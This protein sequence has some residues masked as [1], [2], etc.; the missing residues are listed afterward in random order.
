M[1]KMVNPAELKFRETMQDKVSE[2]INL[3]QEYEGVYTAIIITSDKEIVDG[4]NRTKAALALGIESIPAIIIDAECEKTLRDRG[5]THND[6]CF[7]ASSY[8]ID[9]ED[10]YSD[11]VQNAFREYYAGESSQQCYAEYIEMVVE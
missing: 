6:I 11:E 9:Y 1:F 10:N 5:Y 3:T 8:C 7:A 4:H 2:Y